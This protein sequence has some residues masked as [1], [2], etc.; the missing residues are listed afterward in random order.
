MQHPL[1]TGHNLAAVAPR[2]ITHLPKPNKPITIDNLLLISLTLGVKKLF[3]LFV[4]RKL[5]DF[6][7]E[8]LI[9]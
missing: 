5:V 2:D 4:T 8:T 3:E 6:F 1:A 7:E 9:P